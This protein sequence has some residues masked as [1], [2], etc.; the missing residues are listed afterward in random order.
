MCKKEESLY[1]TIK[2]VEVEV[3]DLLWRTWALKNNEANL[4]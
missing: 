4:I 1:G 3:S 2:F